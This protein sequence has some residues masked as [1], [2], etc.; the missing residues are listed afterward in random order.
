MNRYPAATFPQGSFNR[1]GEI[2]FLGENVYGI[3]WFVVLKEFV[4]YFV[5]SGQLYLAKM[6]KANGKTQV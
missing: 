4:R 3:H 1:H 2:E 6:V 5:T